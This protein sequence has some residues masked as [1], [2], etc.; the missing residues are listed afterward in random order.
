MNVARNCSQ[1]AEPSKDGV[2]SVP[3]P[4]ELAIGAFACSFAAGSTSPV[5]MVVAAK[6]D[7]SATD[8]LFDAVLSGISLSSSCRSFRSNPSLAE[9]TGSTKRA[10][11]MVHTCCQAAA[12]QL[13]AVH[14]REDRHGE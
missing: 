8:V 1:E 2:R 10:Q 9:S 12:S 7:M 13:L 14:A 3:L 4:I 11:Q 5:E 6:L